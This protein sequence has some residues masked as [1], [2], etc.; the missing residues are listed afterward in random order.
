MDVISEWS[1]TWFFILFCL[2]KFLSLRQKFSGISRW[3]NRE[4]FISRAEYSAWGF[5]PHLFQILADPRKYPPSNT[6][7][8]CRKEYKLKLS[9]LLIIFY[10]SHCLKFLL[11]GEIPNT[12]I[13]FNLISLT[14]MLTLQHP[15]KKYQS[16]KW[17]A[18]QSEW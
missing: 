11:N 5:P 15:I 10:E 2:Y 18:E 14:W 12:A 8:D 9:V 13:Y 17:P 7:T 4:S 1:L 3:H 6:A 16:L